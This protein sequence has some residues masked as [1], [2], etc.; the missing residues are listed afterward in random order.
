MKHASSLVA[1]AK[2]IGRD[3]PSGRTF[4]AEELK[5]KRKVVVASLFAATLFAWKMQPEVQKTRAEESQGQ[6]SQSSARHDTVNRAAAD[7]C[8]RMMDMIEHM[9]SYQ[10]Q[11]AVTMTKLTQNV[12]DLQNEKD[13]AQLRAKL[14]EQS[15]MLDELQIYM[16][17]QSNVT[18][19]L[20][21]SLR[22][23]CAVTADGGKPALS[24]GQRL[25]PML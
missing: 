23:N 11:M 7:D 20:E 24:P 1:D 10:R 21:E 17:Q 3:D 18:Q 15:G 4:Q 13:I 8:Q 16:T 25:P 9:T 6:S 19:S 5:M 22:T 2:G 12:A 14:A